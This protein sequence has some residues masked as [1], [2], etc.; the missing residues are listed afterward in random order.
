M[1]KGLVSII[2][3]CFNGSEYI[4]RCIKSILEQNYNDIE[5][6]IINDGSTDD[7]EEKIW[8]YKGDIEKRGYT[9][10]YMLQEN[11]GAAA[12]VN[13]GLKIMTGEFF[14]LFDIDDILYPDNVSKKVKVFDEN[15]N[16]GIVINNGY[17]FNIDSGKRTVFRNDIDYIKNNGLFNAIIYEHAYSWAGCCMMRTEDFSKNIENRDIFLSKYGQNLQVVLPVAFASGS[18]VVDEPLMD[19]VM[20]K[21]SV[22]HTEDVHKQLFLQKK[23]TE[24]RIESVKNIR[25]DSDNKKKII[26]SIEMWDV[27][28]RYIFS[29]NHGLRDELENTKEILKKNKL[30]SFRDNVRYCVGKNKCLKKFYDFLHKLKGSI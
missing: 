25:M 11:Q 27:K 23:F 19:Y 24:N 4:D 13:Q 2:I 15:S 16:V 9:F 7:S 28:K 26:H 30:F 21:N 5:I 17:F 18:Y 6:I 3:P 14:Q 12:A 20:R 1:Q 29:M 22:S 8:S 10:K